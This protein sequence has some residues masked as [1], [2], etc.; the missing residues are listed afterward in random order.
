MRRGM[1]CGRAMQNFDGGVS[2]FGADL[3]L[4]LG[5]YLKFVLESFDMDLL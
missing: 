2:D 5:N 3:T 1:L 4:R